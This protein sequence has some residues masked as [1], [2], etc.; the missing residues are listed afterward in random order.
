MGHTASVGGMWWPL[1]DCLGAL[2]S[3]ARSIVMATSPGLRP[4]AVAWNPAFRRPTLSSQGPETG[5][6]G[7]R[8]DGRR[9][10]LPRSTGARQAFRAELARKAAGVAETGAE[11]IDAFHRS[12]RFTFIHSAVRMSAHPCRLWGPVFSNMISTV[13][14]L[15]MSPMAP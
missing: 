5:V 1:G 6:R 8:E 10:V 4:A 15:P 13:S 12:L 3:E 2:A 14:P 7:M 11:W 9:R